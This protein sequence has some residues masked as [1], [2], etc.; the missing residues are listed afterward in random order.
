MLV[1]TRRIGEEIVIDGRIRVR[2][3]L[4]QRDRVRLGIMAP[5]NVRVDRAEVH[6][7]RGL[8]GPARPPHDEPPAAG[9]LEVPQ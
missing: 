7:C 8:P 5:E 4:V 6:E 2:V 3:T 9:L 1:L